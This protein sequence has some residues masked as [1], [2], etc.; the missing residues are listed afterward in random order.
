MHILVFRL[1]NEDV[2]LA[3]LRKAHPDIGF[4][5]CRASD[6]EEEGRNLVLIDTVPGLK[7]VML[8]DNLHSRWLDEA[9]E[10][11]K[12]ISTLRVLKALGSIDSA[13]VIGVPVDYEAQRAARG[14]S[15][16]IKSLDKG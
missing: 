10:T 11:S 15:S 4:R 7:N 14:I 6:I 13:M 16:A 8:I 9:A 2:I 12:M 1:E 3:S 5:K